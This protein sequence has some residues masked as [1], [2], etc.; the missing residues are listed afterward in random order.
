MP[1]SHTV[2]KGETLVTIAHTHG[3]RDWAPIWNDSANRALRDKRRNPM[4]LVEG[5]VVSIPDKKVLSARCETNKKHRFVVKALVAQ[6]KF[7]L[8]D[9]DGKGMVGVRYKLEVGDE[10][11]EGQTGDEGLIEHEVPHDATEA[12]LSVWAT[13]D[14]KETTWKLGIGQLK[15]ITEVE[16]YEARLSN[17]GYDIGTVDGTADEKTAAGIK[18]FQFDQGIPTSGKMDELTRARL[19]EAYKG[20]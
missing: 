2:A 19:N 6:F 9:D 3:F 10:V 12:K 4:T 17:L 5:D 14:G 1:E 11:F 16:G 13:S 15:P 18:H 8:N 7:N 20:F